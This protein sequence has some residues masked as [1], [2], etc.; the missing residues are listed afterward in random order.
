MNRSKIR[1]YIQETTSA[2]HKKKKTFA[3]SS[4]S[5]AAPT[6]WNNL[7]I[8]VKQANTLVQFKSLLTTYLFGSFKLYLVIFYCEVGILFLNCS[9][10][11]IFKFIWFIIIILMWNMAEND[12]YIHS[13]SAI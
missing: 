3:Q 7:P 6:L 11:Y 9:N 2:T 8:S 10:Y 5:V 13:S 1:V 4:F 12:S